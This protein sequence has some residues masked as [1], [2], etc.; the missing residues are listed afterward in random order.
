[1]DWVQFTIMLLT[2]LGLFAWNRMES[3]KD[4]RHMDAKL[5][6]NRELVRTIHDEVKDFH[7]RLYALE[8]RSKD[9]K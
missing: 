4:M 8:E 2:F 3:R 5:E 6:S 7:A 9:R 1:M